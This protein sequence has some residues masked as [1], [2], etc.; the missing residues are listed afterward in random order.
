MFEIFTKYAG[1]A[2]IGLGVLLV[3]FRAII[4]KNTTVSKGNSY[5]LLTLVTILV[6]L[7][8]M[9]SIAAW[10]YLSSQRTVNN[11]ETATGARRYL[12]SDIKVRDQKFKTSYKA[13]NDIFDKIDTVKVLI[14]SP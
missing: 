1:I 2:G 10:T 5:K 8:A 9:T 7:T 4:G 13:K 12:A 11:V 6:W 3:L 14:N